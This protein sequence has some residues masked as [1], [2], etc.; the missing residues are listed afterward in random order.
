MSTENF[1]YSKIDTYN[2]CGFKYKL[3]YVDHNFFKFDSVATE[4]GTLIHA[5][6]EAIGKNIMAGATIDYIALKNNIIRASYDL[7]YRYKKPWAELDK[8]ERTYQQKVY[9]YLTTGIYRLE[10]FMQANKNLEIIGVE[11]KFETTYNGHTFKGIIDRVLRDRNTGKYIIQDIKTYPQL[12]E[13]SKLK[14]PLQFV[15][16]VLAAKE[17]YGCSEAD[18]ACQYDLPLCD[19]LQDAG[20]FGF[21]TKGLKELDRFFIQVDAGNFEPNPTPLC[22]WCQFCGTNPDQPAGAKNL[23]PYHSLW[24]KETKNS[25]TAMPWTGLENYDIMVQKYIATYGGTV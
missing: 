12:I 11:Q 15:I 18:V 24:T 20:E 21:M 13:K 2:Q 25:Q 19:T 14:V 10:H 6:E 8:S 5:T 4:F 9:E 16:Y 1:S 3:V 17:L 22:H 7:Q 23:C